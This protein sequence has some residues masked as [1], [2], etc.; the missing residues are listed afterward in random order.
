METEN[1]IYFYSLKNDYS[2]MSNFYKTKFY[3]ENGIE[4]NCSEQYFMFYK[5]KTFDAEN[6]ELLDNILNETTPTKIKKYGRKVK[7]YND[8]IWNE[9]R[10]DIM[11]NGLKLKFSQNEIIKNK[12]LLTKPKI[13]YEASPKDKIWGIGFSCNNATSVDKNEFGKNLLG[14]ALMTV[15]DLL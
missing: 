11:L 3:D 8:I 14:K 5:C 1:E 15:R 9:K 6:K 13:L 10:Y 12:L 4:F 7:N 2:Y